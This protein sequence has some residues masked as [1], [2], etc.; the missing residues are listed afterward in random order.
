MSALGG[1]RVRSAIALAREFVGAAF[2]FAGAKL[3]KIGGELLDIDG[4]TV[5]V[6]LTA[7]DFSVTVARRAC[8]AWGRL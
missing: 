2:T 1:P 4:A 3:V 8:G 6:R 7:G 5:A